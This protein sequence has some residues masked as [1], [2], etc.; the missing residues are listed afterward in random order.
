M[1]VNRYKCKNCD[2]EFDYIDIP[3]FDGIRYCEICG[4][5]MIKEFPKRVNIFFK[6]AFSSTNYCKEGNK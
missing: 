3:H 1:P 5:L 4:K 2:E 6:G